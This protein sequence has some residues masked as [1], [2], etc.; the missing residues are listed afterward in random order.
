MSDISVTASVFLEVEVRLS[1]TYVPGYPETGPTYACG[2][3][4]AEPAGLED[5]TVTDILALIRDK[6]EPDGY[7]RLSLLTG[8]A[9]ADDIACV[10]SNVLEAVGEEDATYA[11]LADLPEEYDT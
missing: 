9:R 3:T 11:L 6:T 1:G 2:G 5:V 7:R 8:H 10:F 4:P